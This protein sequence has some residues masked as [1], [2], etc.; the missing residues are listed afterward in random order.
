MMLLLISLGI[1]LLLTLILE[2]GFALLWSIRTPALRRGR[3]LTIVALVNILTNPVVVLL[4][5]YALSRHSGY[6]YG[7]VVL[8]EIG[9]I[10]VEWVCYRAC[11][12]ALRRPFLFSL[13]AN[14]FSVLMGF[15]LT[16]LL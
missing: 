8:L 16:A 7:F 14:L 6:P 4:A 13:C 1:S 5:N 2:F 9:A 15:A 10:L 11:S 3:E 12:E